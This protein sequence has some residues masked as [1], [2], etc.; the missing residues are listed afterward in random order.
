MVNAAL[1]RLH[2]AGVILS[3]SQAYPTGPI[4]TINQETWQDSIYSSIL[5]PISLVQS[6]LPTVLSLLMRY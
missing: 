3:L 6:F 2:L 1:G 5:E 4:E